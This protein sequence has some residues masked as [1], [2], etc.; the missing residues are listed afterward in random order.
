LT[1][2][3]KGMDAETLSKLESLGY[4]GSKV[5]TD[6]LIDLEKEDPKNLIDYHVLSN[7]IGYLAQIEEYE[8]AEKNCLKMIE[9]RPDLYMG[10]YKMS[11]YLMGRQQY[12]EAVDYITKVAELEPDFALAYVGLAKAYE[13]LGQFDIAIKNALRALEI[14]RDSVG[15]YYHLSLCYY[16]KGMFDEPEK[17]LNKEISENPNYA[18]VLQ[19]LALELYEKGQIQYS[20]KKY[21]MLL[22]KDPVSID[23]LNSLAWFQAASTIEGIHNPQ[24]AVKHALKACEITEYANSKTLDTLSVAY[25]ASGDFEKAVETSQK[26]IEVAK[27]N[28]EEAL[29]GRMQKRQDL[30]RQEKPY[31]DAGLKP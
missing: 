6:F 13:N 16:E 22:E 9:K 10:Y 3:G 17:H 31:V 21:L 15:A 2:D 25:A 23:G 30:Y 14:E 26:A 28:S 11:Q 8:A 12:S 20:F 19:K 1:A 5:E 7:T 24:Q 29:A 4:V 27:T 18:K